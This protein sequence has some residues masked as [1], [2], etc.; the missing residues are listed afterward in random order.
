MKNQNKQ[1]LW[2]KRI[3]KAELFD[4]SNQAFCSSEGLSLATF[5]YWKKRLRPRQNRIAVPPSP[6]VKVAIERVPASLPDPQWVAELILSLCRG[7][8]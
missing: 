5:Q 6:F 1:E 3:T 8:K 2:E 4:G 7:L